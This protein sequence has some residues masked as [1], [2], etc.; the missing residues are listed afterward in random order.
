MQR[1][2]SRNG[3]V[4]ADGVAHVTVIR[5]LGHFSRPTQPGGQSTLQCC[6]VGRNWGAGAAKA[7]EDAICPCRLP[8]LGANKAQVL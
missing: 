8:L 6:I 3:L 5:M 7:P 4:I 2:V 1:K